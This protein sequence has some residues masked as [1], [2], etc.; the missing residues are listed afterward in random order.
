MLLIPVVVVTVVF[1]GVGVVTGPLTAVSIEISPAGPTTNELGAT[2]EVESDKVS[3]TVF[4]VY[5][6]QLYAIV[7]GVS[8]GVML[9]VAGGK[10]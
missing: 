4:A 6:R 8:E 7:I 2:P 1:L 10:L 3:D 5:P 9:V